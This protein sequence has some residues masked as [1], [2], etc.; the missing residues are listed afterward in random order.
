MP[1]DDTSLWEKDYFVKASL[2]T[3]EYINHFSEST[4]G[5]ED[6]HLQQAT[7]KYDN[8]EESP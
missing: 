1:S 7:Q 5:I 4:T 2:T 8:D 3:N 6:Q